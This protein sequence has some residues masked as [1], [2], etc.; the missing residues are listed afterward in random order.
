LIA[1][2]F[3]KGI[4]ICIMTIETY[5]NKLNDII[6][7]PQFEKVCPK[8][9]NEKYPIPKEEERV[10]SLLKK[11]K[12]RNKITDTLFDKL[13]PTGS[14]P[15]R[16]YGLAKIHKDSVPVRPVLSMPGSAYYNIANQ[17]AKWL[18]VVKECN[19]N[20]PQNLFLITLKPLS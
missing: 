2:P 12:D 4:G 6:Q 18:S 8:R 16:L 14:Q 15:P 1:V 13:K 10:T 11:L 9:K 20:H 7:L 3:D 19:I 5:N 17:V